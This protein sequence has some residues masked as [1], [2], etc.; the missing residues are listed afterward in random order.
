MAL[1]SSSKRDMDIKTAGSSV[2]Q[3]QPSISGRK[4]LKAG[5]GEPYGHVVR[6][7]LC[8]RRLLYYTHALG[9]AWGDTR[10]DLGGLNG[11]SKAQGWV[12]LEKSLIRPASHLW[13]LRSHSEPSSV[14]VREEAKKAGFSPTIRVFITDGERFGIVGSLQ[15]LGVNPKRSTSMLFR[16]K[17]GAIRAIRTIKR[18]W[19]IGRRRSA[20]PMSSAAQMYF[21]CFVYGSSRLSGAIM[22]G[23]IL[24]TCI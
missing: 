14:W 23:L 16:F 12:A 20:A 17:V 15:G 6:K 7:I 19:V 24:P 11:P 10:K 13:D 2:W 9:L 21:D 3:P 8:M 4:G 18:F 1:L 5:S 22:W